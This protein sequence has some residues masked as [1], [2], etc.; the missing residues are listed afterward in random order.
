MSD[1]NEVLYI[2]LEEIIQEA[3]YIISMLILIISQHQR[4]KR[5]RDVRYSMIERMPDQATHMGRLVFGHQSDCLEN[6]RMDRNAFGRLCYLLRNRG[7]LIDGKFV[8]VEEQVAVFLSVLGH[9]KKNRVVKFDHKRS[10]QTISHYIHLVLRSVLQVHN[11]LLVRPTPVPNDCTNPRLSRRF[12]WNIYNVRVPAVDKGR[13]RTRKGQISTNVLAVCDRELRFVYVLPG[14]EGSASDA[15]VLRDSV[16]WVN[17]LKVPVGNYYLCDNGYA[18]SPGFLSPYRGVRY[19]LSEWGP[20]S[21]RPTNAQEH[22]NMRHT[23]ARNVIERAFGI[24]KMR[25][26][27]LRSASFYPIRTQIRLIMACFLLH[28]FIRNEMPIDPLEGL[29]DVENNKQ[30]GTDENAEVISTVEATDEW[31]GW[32]DVLAQEMY[33]VFNNAV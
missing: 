4:N 9:H 27:I 8:S 3:F 13:Y 15:R 10:G 22:Y 12:R 18:N 20:Q 6:L 19:H 24:M 28:N 23:R 2:M 17:G 29:L 5:K 21:D 26:G 25:W 7:G 32:R 33:H 11:V 14:W 30:V 31:S 16:N 1:S